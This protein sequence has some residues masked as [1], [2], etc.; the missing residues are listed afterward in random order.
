MNNKL[1]T[2]LAIFLFASTVSQAQF[3]KKNRE[4]GTENFDE[5]GRLGYDKFHHNFFEGMREYGLENYE[6][7]IESFEKCLQMDPNSIA[8]HFQLS[9]VYYELGQK[10]KAITSA[11]QSFEL[12]KSNKDTY[13]NY[14]DLCLNSR[15][16]SFAIIATKDFIETL[17]TSSEIIK[18]KKELARIY[19]YNREPA[20]AVLVY[21]ELEE[22]FG[23]T[24]GYANERLRL[25]K[26]MNQLDEALTEVDGLIE[27]ND[28]SAG[29]LYQKAALLNQKGSEEEALVYY[30]KA[31]TA[32]PN[33]SKSLIESGELL[34]KKKETEEGVERIKK[35]FISNELEINDKVNAFNRLNSTINSKSTILELAK[36]LQSA[37]ENSSGA[38]KALSDAYFDMGDKKT[39]VEYL[40]KAKELEPNN[41][42]Y[43]VDLVNTYYELGDYI[44]LR[45]WSVQAS[46]LYPSHHI[47]YLY[48]G[49]A[50]S[51]LEDFSNAL[52]ML[53]TGKS[54][55]VGQT[56]TK[57]EFELAIADVYYN[58]GEYNTA[59]RKYEELIESQSQNPLVLNNYAYFLAQ[60]NYRLKDAEIYVK[61]ALEFEPDNASYLDTYG[62]IHFKNEKYQNAIEKYNEALELANNNGEILEHKGDAVFKLGNKTEAVKLWQMAK[63]NGNNSETLMLKIKNEKYYEE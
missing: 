39:G 4:V 21:N 34:I 54:Y 28:G 26:Q 36:A 57:V 35:A 45:K 38:N 19:E 23:Y 37:H 3:W 50:F 47:F 13:H 31:L 59:E 43:S 27:N 20:E 63:E 40:A 61:K 17:T 55:A 15:S 10:S 24:N 16:F 48:A 51:E 25:Y 11:R 49:I 6:K 33:H 46:E 42:N 2:V 62:Y 56:A 44:N 22:E 18:Y 8:V 1:K 30:N 5:A 60:R 12:D 53:E 29:Y 58:M 14:K 41:F 9:R 52:M 7:S 32:N